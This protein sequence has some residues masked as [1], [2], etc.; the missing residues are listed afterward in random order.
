VGE[1]RAEIIFFK[2]GF[3]IP[4]FIETSPILFFH[5]QHCKQKDNEQVIE[6]PARQ[7]CCRTTHSELI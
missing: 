5:A 7:G 2:D 1:V 4:N 3:L 6:L